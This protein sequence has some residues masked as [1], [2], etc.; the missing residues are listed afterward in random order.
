MNKG[1]GKL[2]TMWHHYSLQ[3]WFPSFQ[4]PQQEKHFMFLNSIH[5]CVST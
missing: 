1:Q 3:Q 2:S 5:T 4:N